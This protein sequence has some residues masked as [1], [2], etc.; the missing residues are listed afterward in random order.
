MRGRMLVKQNVRERERNLLFK[1]F[2]K[3][4]KYKRKGESH[5]TNRDP[6]FSKEQQT[7]ISSEST[8]LPTDASGGNRS[9]LRVNFALEC[10]CGLDAADKERERR[11][12]RKK[13]LSGTLRPLASWRPSTFSIA[14][15]SCIALQS[16][17]WLILDPCCGS[18]HL[19]DSLF[20]LPLV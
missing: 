1:H 11:K 2:E 13:T 16:C 9:P 20:L 3:S 17:L 12:R 19:F 14:R 15:T 18:L 4:M 6:A 10:S 8:S 7:S 5:H